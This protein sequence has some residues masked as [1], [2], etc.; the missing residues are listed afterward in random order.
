ML[1]I[2]N[3]I[4]EGKNIGMKRIGHDLEQLTAYRVI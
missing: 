1:V 4:I 2:W 3:K